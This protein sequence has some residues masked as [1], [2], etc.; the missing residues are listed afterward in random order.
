MDMYP[1]IFKRGKY[2]QIET[3][4]NKRKSL[5][6]TDQKEAQKLLIR[7]KHAELEKKIAFLDAGDRLSLSEFVERWTG[8][9]DRKHLS[10]DT[11]RADRL[12]FKSLIDVVGDIP[13]RLVNKEAI[14][15]FKDITSGRV[16]MSSVNTY[17]RHI[18]A[19]LNWAKKQ[20]YIK[21]VPQIQ[22]YR[23][24]KTLPRFLS[25]SDVKKLLE[26]S[27]K[28]KPEM[29]RV[30]RFALYTGAR[31]REIVAARYE[32]IID[33]EI[34]IKGKGD[35]ERMVPVSVE[36]LSYRQD[37]GKIFSYNHVSTVSNYFREI[38]RAAGVKAR[39]HD[40]RHTAGTYML[41]ADI[42]LNV[43]QD[44]LGHS[45]IRTTE[46][47]AKVLAKTRIQEMRKL[48]YE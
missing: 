21:K 37:I 19:G 2:W 25:M 4:R 47:Y 16:S 28:H 24:G 41:A 26:Y 46:I 20:E 32:H 22:P 3:A 8:N 7:Y 31:R 14:W 34:K 15:R 9:P 11:L 42:P 6:V 13:L 17:L 44:I 43:I 23:T 33:G 38:T 35:K 39:F 30:I 29:Y 5:G 45:D 1:K 48:S 10:S 40:L 27:E 18:K 12:A 36:A